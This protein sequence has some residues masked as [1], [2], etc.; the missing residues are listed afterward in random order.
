MGG[1]GDYETGKEVKVKDIDRNGKKQSG[2][3]KIHDKIVYQSESNNTLI[4]IRLLLLTA[5][6]TV[7]LTYRQTMSV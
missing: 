3:R 5:N 4:L 1:K 6:L 2:R 7:N